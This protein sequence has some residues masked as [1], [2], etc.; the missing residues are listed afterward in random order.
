MTKEQREIARRWC[1]FNA[2]GWPEG[3]AK[4]D[5]PHQRFVV[6]V[7][8][9]RSAVRAIGKAR[10]LEFWNSEEFKAEHVEREYGPLS[11]D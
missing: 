11:D 6:A 9:M 4:P 1:I 10:C 2:W 3:I 8:Y 7:E 5:L